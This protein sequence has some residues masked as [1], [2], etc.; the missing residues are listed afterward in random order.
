MKQTLLVL[1]TFLISFSSWAEPIDEQTAKAVGQQFFS[2]IKGGDNLRTGLNLK[3]AYKATSKASNP[4]GRI[5]QNVF[6]YAFNVNEA[7]GFILISGDD[8]VA[9]VLGYS[10]QN[11]FDPKGLPQNVRKWLE[12]YKKEIQYLIE[13][14]IQATDEVKNEWARLSGQASVNST[15]RVASVNPL[16][17]TKWN[18]NPFYNDLA[19][20]DADSQ[21]KT[22][23]GCVA[24]A[25]AQ[26]MKYWNYPATGSGFH[27]YKHPKYGTLAANFSSTAYDWASMP[28]QVNS[29]NLAVATLMYQIGVS[30]DMNYDIAANGGSGAYVVS[31]ASPVDHNSEHALKTYFGY[32][33][34]LRGVQRKHY[35]NTTWVNLLKSELDARRPILF[36]GFGNG[37][38]HAF[39]CDGYDANQL[40]HFNWGWG[41]AYDGYYRIDAL[42]PDG[43]GTGGGSGGY[44]SGQQ[45]V[46]G[47][48]PPTA[49]QSYGLKL[50]NTL[51][52]SA[53]SIAYG[54]PFS[55]TTNIL[56]SGTSAFT[57][58]Y[59]AAIFDESSNFVDFVEVKTGASLSAGYTYSNNLTFSYAGSLGLLP[60]DYKV[61]LFYR[62]TGGQWKLVA[63]N[64]SYTNN[65]QL[66]IVNANNIEL[67]ADLRLINNSNLT[68]GQGITVSFDIANRGSSSFTG[69]VSLDLYN[70]D[71]SHAFTIQEAANLSICSNCH[72]QNGLTFTNP[73]LTVTPGT[74]LLAATHMPNGGSWQ[75]IGSTS[76]Q[77]PIKVTVMAAPLQADMYE[78]ND[79]V[80]QAYKL[81]LSFSG[82]AAQVSTQSSNSHIGT[83]LDYYKLE[84]PA[85][86]TY[87]INPSL[88]DAY[89][90]TGTAY[91]LDALFSY[92]LDGV[93]WSDAYDDAL[94]NSI[95]VEGGRTIYLGVA[96]YFSGET[97]TYLLNVEVTRSSA[98]ALGE[99]SAGE[100]IVVYPNPV[101]DRIIVDLSTFEG[102]LEKA[103]L[104]SMQGKVVLIKNML[105]SG[106]SEL[107]VGSVPEGL[108]I[109]QLYTNKGIITR[110]IIIAR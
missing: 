32:K 107:S 26:I 77:N 23:T 1:L 59:A 56:N 18:Q 35:T 36:A 109:L 50:N 6:Y 102:Q 38:G 67:Y 75:L 88:Q 25:M 104:V 12:G 34:T 95:S 70:L 65:L 110:K 39:V 29:S 45:A 73:N 97:G 15:A 79:A 68:Q 99:S 92:S 19:P 3:L 84:L 63:N 101:K 53:N 86:Y 57:G 96:P 13:N 47:I 89:S 22:V 4:N 21:Q 2:S 55:V 87:T 91:S 58:D 11:G 42:N 80:G 81:P 17:T 8:K 82:A 61:H 74:Y 48:E 41:G 94:P 52:A 10:D 44:N 24:T 54:Q 46:I 69:T 78:S 14:N 28:D 5:Q 51:T 62:P 85:G 90:S 43:V 16:M 106:R 108:Y 93:S 9:P 76:Y 7:D 64:A 72:F 49:A 71:G 98:L 100:A 27:S 37:G 33:S 83:D 40:F 105:D 20:Y 60:G 66:R 31:A 103:K 30:V